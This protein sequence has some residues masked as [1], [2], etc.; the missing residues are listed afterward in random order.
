MADNLQNFLLRTR[1]YVRELDTGTSFW[2][3]LFLTQ[4]F[5]ASYR[6]RCAALIIAFEG[7]FSLVATRDLVEGQEA[8]GFPDGLSRLLKLEIVRTDG[9]RVPLR[10]Y[11]RHETANPANN[12]QS[13]GDGYLPTFRPFSNGFVLE[14]PPIETVTDALRM[15]YTGLPAFL[16]S[17]G[18]KLHPSFPELFDEMIVLDTVCS[19][20]DAEGLHELGPIPS[21]KALR[22]QWTEDFEQYIQSRVVARQRIEPT[23]GPYFDY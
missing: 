8:Y 9:T 13:T 16:S 17:A 14:P 6:R 10:R 3:D 15:E 4:M 12:T 1:R 5:N 11:E 20:L 18:D 21:I 2:T 22:D 19:A 23:F 7:W